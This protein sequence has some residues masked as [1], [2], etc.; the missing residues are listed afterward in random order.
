MV[1]FYAS[2]GGCVE[3]AKAATNRWLSDPSNQTYHNIMCI[4]NNRSRAAFKRAKS[5]AKRI[6]KEKELRRLLIAD[7]LLR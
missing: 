3:C 1:R 6:A 5:E 4:S 2:T 7:C